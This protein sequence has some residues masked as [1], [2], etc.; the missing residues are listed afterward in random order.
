MDSAGGTSH[1]EKTGTF[2]KRL[3]CMLELGE[4]YYEN[5]GGKK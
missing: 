5:S 3:A 1:R 2:L 4:F